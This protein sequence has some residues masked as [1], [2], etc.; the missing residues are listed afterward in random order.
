MDAW[1]E[2]LQRKDLT[3]DIKVKA[4]TT[5]SLPTVKFAN[6][7]EK[8]VKDA[9]PEEAWR[10]REEILNLSKCVNRRLTQLEKG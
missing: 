7:A 10:Y 1:D 3:L 8:L 2:Y 6:L 4:L 9:T 5:S